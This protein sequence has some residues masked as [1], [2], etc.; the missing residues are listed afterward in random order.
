MRVNYCY[1]KFES[2]RCLAPKPQNTSKEECCCSPMPGQGWGDP[3]EICPSKGEGANTFCHTHLCSKKHTFACLSCTKLCIMFNGIHEVFFNISL[4][5]RR[6]LISVPKPAIRRDQTTARK[7]CV[8]LIL[9][10]HRPA[11]L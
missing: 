1:T 3:C 8:S 2:G 5:Q 10:L 4:F 11:S 9:N 6:I 7:V